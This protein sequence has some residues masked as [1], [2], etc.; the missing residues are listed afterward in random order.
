[1]LSFE[2]GELFGGGGWDM[3]KFIKARGT[4]RV[5]EFRLTDFVTF[6]LLKYIF[7]A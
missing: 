4:R 6:T 1:M 2:I 5:K 3:S 7:T